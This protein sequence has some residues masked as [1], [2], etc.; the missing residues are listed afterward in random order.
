MS[1]RRI[2]QLSFADG[3]VADAAWANGTLRRISELVDW[4]EVEVLVRGLRSGAMG[5][6]GYPALALFQGAFAPAVLWAV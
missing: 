1:E 3:L 4:K 5:A 2:G 6:P